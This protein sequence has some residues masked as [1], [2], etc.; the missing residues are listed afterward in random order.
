MARFEFT[1]TQL[2]TKQ[3]VPQPHLVG[4][5]HVDLAIGGD[6]LDLALAEVTFNVSAVEPPQLSRQ[7]MMRLIS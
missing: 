1:L 2:T 3:L 4:V 5:D 7:P 6:L